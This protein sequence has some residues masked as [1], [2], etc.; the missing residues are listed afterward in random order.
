MTGWRCGADC[1]RFVEGGVSEAHS[2]KKQRS[3]HLQ[4]NIACQHSH[5]NAFFGVGLFLS[6]ENTV[7]RTGLPVLW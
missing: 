4:K 3:Q 6:E 5:A 7:D 1:R 2:L